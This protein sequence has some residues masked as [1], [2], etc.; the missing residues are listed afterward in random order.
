MRMNKAGRLRIYSDDSDKHAGKPIYQWLIEEAHRKG[1]RGA[2]ATRGV[3]GFGNHDEIHSS[4]VFALSADMPV[5]VEVID[6]R[7]KLLEF[8]N[9]IDRALENI[10]A[11]FDEVDIAILGA[12]GS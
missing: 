1:L 12:S 8:V 5:V 3:M 4:K 9:D 11:T 2:T 10:L 7:E 6:S